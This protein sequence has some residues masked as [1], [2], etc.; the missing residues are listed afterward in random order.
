MTRVFV[1][2]NE[3]SSIEYV[4]SAAIENKSNSDQFTQ[5][6]RKVK[7][8]KRQKNTSNGELSIKSNT[9]PSRDRKKYSSRKNTNIASSIKTR[10]NRINDILKNKSLHN[11]N[12]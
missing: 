1:I 2:E 4:S 12:K 8:L 10:Q 9:S 3:I 11:I 6:S 7:T 5:Q